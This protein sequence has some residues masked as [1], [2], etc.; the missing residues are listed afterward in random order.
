[1]FCD[2]T[3]AVSWLRKLR[4]SKSDIAGRLLRILG[5]RIHSLKS[6]NLT[7]LHVAGVDNQI[8][9][10]VSRS[11]KT[12]QYFIAQNSLLT[13]FNKTYPLPQN[14]SWQEC[15]IPQE[16][17]SR[18][19]SSLRGKQLPL[20][21]LLRLPKPGRNT[22]IIGA[23]MPPCAKSTLSSPPLSLPLNGTSSSQPSLRGCGR[24]RTAEELKLEFQGSRM[25]S[26]PSPRP[27][28]WLENKVPSTGRT[29]GTRFR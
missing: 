20:G 28:N 19:I 7:P 9:D 6:S 21:S 15:Q 2:N 14:E 27:L 13:Y 29:K 4:T 25:L 24:V 8:A 26:R 3:S 11:F 17:V 16:W 18:V 5:L 1:M 22:G 23:T 10:V 12:G